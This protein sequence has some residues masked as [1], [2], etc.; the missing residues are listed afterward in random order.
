[1]TYNQVYKTVEAFGGIREG[2]IDGE[3]FNVVTGEAGRLR[4]AEVHASC[5]R[6]GSVMG[7]VLRDDLAVLSRTPCRRSAFSKLLEVVVGMRVNAL[8]ITL[9]RER[10]TAVEPVT[11]QLKPRAHSVR[12]KPWAYSTKKAA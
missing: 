1:M 3:E 12:A 4:T 11:A 8:R 10:P 9:F 5:R 2:T 6:N 7:G